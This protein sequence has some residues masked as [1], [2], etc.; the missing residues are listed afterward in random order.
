[1]LRAGIPFR[2]PVGMRMFQLLEFTVGLFG[3]LVWRLWCRVLEPSF[4]TV[5]MGYAY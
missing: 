1:M 4:P 3:V 5:F 2:I